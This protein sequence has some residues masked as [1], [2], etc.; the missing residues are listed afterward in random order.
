MSKESGKSRGSPSVES[1]SGSNSTY[2]P[3]DQWPKVC[4]C[5]ARWWRASW[6]KLRLLGQFPTDKPEMEMR[7]CRCHSTI[8]VAIAEP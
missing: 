1:N 7:V 8:A 5:G 3:D 2:V 4:A 6:E